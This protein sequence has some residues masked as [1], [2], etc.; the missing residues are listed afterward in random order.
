MAEVVPAFSSPI[1]VTGVD[2]DFPKINWESLEFTPYNIESVGYRTVDQ[3]V[4]DSFP[5]LEGWVFQH[6]LDNVIGAMGVDPDLHWPEITCS[7]INKYKKGQASVPHHHANSMYSGNIFL[8]GDTGNLVFEKPKHMVVEPT[9]SQQNLYN[10]TSFTLPPIESVLCMFPSDL[11]HHTLPNE[12]ESDRITLSFNVMV[13][14]QP[15][16]IEDNA[17]V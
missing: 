17:N 5:D 1:Y 12:S 9:L 13:R 14:G 8:Q 11:R 2:K 3:H 15:R 16:W 7:W 6:V 4:L 10:S